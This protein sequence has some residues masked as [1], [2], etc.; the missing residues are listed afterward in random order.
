[1]DWNSSGWAVEPDSED[2]R[3]IWLRTP[4]TREYYENFTPILQFSDF[5]RNNLEGTLDIKYMA[6]I[7][8]KEL[9]LG[10]REPKFSRQ[11]LPVDS[12]IA[13]DVEDKKEEMYQILKSVAL[14][15]Q[16]WKNSIVDTGSNSL[17]RPHKTR[18][19]MD[20]EAG[21]KELEYNLN[22][23]IEDSS[24]TDVILSGKKDITAYLY[25]V[26]K[27]IKK[28]EEAGHVNLIRLRSLKFNYEPEVYT[29]AV[30]NRLESFN[31]VSITNPKK[32]EIETGFLHS[33]EF[34]PSHGEL[35]SLLAQKGITVYNNTPLIKLYK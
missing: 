10:S 2:E 1:M 12:Y 20:M 35:S 15:N 9:Y 16:R 4:Y 28:L 17:F 24:I 18:V 25:R 19:E 32:L 21:E 33:R 3:Y 27:I 5:V 29:R 22:Y 8:D 26:G 14:N 7:G 13:K 31:K 6:D 11:V 30:I 23:I 34:K